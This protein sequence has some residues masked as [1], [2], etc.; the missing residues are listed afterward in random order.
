M[1]GGMDTRDEDEVITGYV[2][3]HSIPVHWVN[4]WF[5]LTDPSAR[6]ALGSLIFEPGGEVLRD[7]TLPE[8]RESVTRLVLANDPLRTLV[9]VELDKLLDDT[10]DKVSQDESENHVAKDRRSRNSN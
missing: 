8:I 1:I 4:W 6:E 5:A 9:G 7:L 2:L 3:G 10:A